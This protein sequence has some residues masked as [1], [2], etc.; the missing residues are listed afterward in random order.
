MSK[1]L[2]IA[3]CCLLLGI[4]LTAC[5]DAN[6]RTESNLINHKQKKITLL[7]KS[8]P[9]NMGTE[10]KRKPVEQIGIGNQT[11]TEEKKIVSSKSLTGTSLNIEGIQVVAKPDSIPVLVNKQNRLP[12][13]YTPEDLI[14]TDIPFIISERSE[15]R[16]MRREAA[17]AIEK[18]FTGASLQGIQ[19]LGVSAYRS[20]SAQEALFNFYAKRDGYEKARTYSALAGT[21]EHETGLA[22]DVTGGNGQ[23]PAQDCFG[24]TKE[25]KW[26]RE[27]VANF[28][29]IIRYPK[30]KEAI[31]GYTYEPW[32]LRY[33]GSAIAKEV[34]DR[35]ITL[36]EYYH[37]LPVNQ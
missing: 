17:G 36:E 5:S 35:E 32:H 33:V 31:T 23:C 7:D 13:S 8:T 19:L 25:A 15:R 12:D 34:M 3:L 37:A 24:F 30:G 11:S 6:Q 21:S 22:I 2:S 20:H 4:P 18:L 1:T 9:L 27:H 26:L 28:G 29:F 14:Y 10:S 16:K